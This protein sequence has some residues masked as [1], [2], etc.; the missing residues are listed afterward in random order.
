MKKIIGKLCI[1][2]LCIL[3]L[4]NCNKAKEKEGDKE[5]ALMEFAVKFGEMIQ[6]KDIDGIKEVYS[7]AGNINTAHLTFYRDEIDIFPES[8]NLY[9]IRYSKGAYIIVKVGLNNAMEVVKSDGIFDNTNYSKNNSSRRSN[10]VVV[11]PLNK[12]R[13]V[14]TSRL[15]DYDWLSYEY[16]SDYDLE[17][18]NGSELRIM[19]NYIFARHGYIFQSDDLRRYFNQYSWYNPR[20]NDVSSSL[21]KI[22]KANINKIRSYE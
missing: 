12:N 20:Y 4:T 14:S 8:D 19:R 15:P 2:T 13:D 16:V 6:N 18:M 21:N 5:Q 3:S 10:N 11:A 7:D 1:A 22:E 9:K 17:K